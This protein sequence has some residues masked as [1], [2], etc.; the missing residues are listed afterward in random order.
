M[1]D[2]VKKQLILIVENSK[3][4]QQYYAQELHHYATIQQATTIEEGSRLVA[5]Y[6]DNKVILI[7]DG[8]LSHHLYALAILRIAKEI[9][10]K[11]QFTP[12]IVSGSS[13][14]KDNEKLIL[15][16][17]TY[18]AKNKKE[19]VPIVKKILEAL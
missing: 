4:C 13:T 17:C 18:N 12:I 3:A 10:T 7:L 8:T 6:F 9:A 16:G 11:K 1:A 5:D 19:V 2:I 14:E 15:S